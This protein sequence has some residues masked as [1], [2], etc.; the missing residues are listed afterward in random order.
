VLD[1]LVVAVEYSHNWDYSRGKGGTGRQADGVLLDVTY[2][3]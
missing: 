2:T 1:A 3:W